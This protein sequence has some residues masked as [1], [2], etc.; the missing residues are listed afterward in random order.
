MLN[1]PTPPPPPPLPRGPLSPT[2]SAAQ[3]TLVSW[4]YLWPNKTFD[5]A[6]ASFL[7]PT[8]NPSPP[9]PPPPPSKSHHITSLQ[10][11]MA[12][13]LGGVC[14]S[15]AAVALR[16]SMSLCLPSSHS[17]SCATTLL[18]CATFWSIT[19]SSSFPP[20][21]PPPPPTPPHT[22]THAH[23]RTH[24]CALPPLTPVSGQVTLLEVMMAK[25]SNPSAAQA[26]MWATSGARGLP[27]PLPPP[28]FSSSSWS[29]AGHIASFHAGANALRIVLL[30]C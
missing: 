27:P 9:P 4:T 1:A 8:P 28:H 20:P 6:H 25:V 24:A 23:A 5:Q 13:I 15:R 12:Q 2:P 19:K 7:K 14:C 17:F 10:V 21:P 3:T 29:R 30:H 16:S 18:F 26:H 22:H 11:M